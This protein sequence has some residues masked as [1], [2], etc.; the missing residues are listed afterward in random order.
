MKEYPRIKTVKALNFDSFRRSNFKK[1]KYG[2]HEF[3]EDKD[4]FVHIYTDSYTDEGS[5]GCGVFAVHYGRDH[6]L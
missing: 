3:E 2:D 6:P 1:V 4:G 5:D